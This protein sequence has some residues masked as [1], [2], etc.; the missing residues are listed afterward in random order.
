MLISYSCRLLGRSLS[1]P[2]YCQTRGGFRPP[3]VAWKPQAEAA[4]R[5]VELTPS[6]SSSVRRPGW[7]QPIHASAERMRRT[8]TAH[9]PRNLPNESRELS[10][11][12]SGAEA[13]LT[14]QCNLVEGPASMSVLSG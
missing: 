8:A 1:G 11:V 7:L 9:A 4:L 2:R 13:T 6:I 3:A 5:P 14:V 10:H 12:A